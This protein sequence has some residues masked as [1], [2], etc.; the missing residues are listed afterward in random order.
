MTGPDGKPMTGPDGAPLEKQKPNYKPTGL[1]AKEANTVSGTTTVL[2]YHEPPEARKPPSSQQWR[3]YV[4][5]GKDLL[6]TIH[7]H[8]RSAWLLGRDEKVTDY[9]IEHPS[10]SKQH[11][12]IQ[13]RYIS[14][15]DEFGTKT[16]RV[17]PYLIDLESVHGTRLNGKKIAPSKYTELLNDD[18]VTFGE[19]EREY[20]VM[21]PEVE[22]KS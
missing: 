13:F 18:V 16:G 17:K 19:S 5:K 14:K 4:F 9:L 15:V 12:V 20:V 10:A 22:K 6:D 3:I 1:L 21:L 2:K 7:L 11:A 8:T